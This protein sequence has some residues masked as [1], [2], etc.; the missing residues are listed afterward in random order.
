[1]RLTLLAVTLLATCV[2]VQSS[3]MLVLIHW[4]ARV[5]HV[6]ESQTCVASRHTLPTFTESEGHLSV[7][8]GLLRL[9][10]DRWP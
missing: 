5:H 3:G 2:I 9:Q 4:L 7:A 6:L 1:M 8:A 10:R